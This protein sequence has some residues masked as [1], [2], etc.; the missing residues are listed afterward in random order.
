MKKH[1]LPAII[2]VIT[3]WGCEPTTRLYLTPPVYFGTPHSL[4]ATDSSKKLAISSSAILPTNAE[5]KFQYR[6]NEDFLFNLSY[7]GNLG[8]YSNFNNN[9]IDYR[10]ATSSFDLQLGYAG[11]KNTKK[12]FLVISA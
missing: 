10:Y 1:F 7:F 2:L 9:N 11:H 3:L 8:A 4:P 5:V 12:E 6:I